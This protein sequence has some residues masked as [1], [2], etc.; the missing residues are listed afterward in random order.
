MFAQFMTIADELGWD[1]ERQ[2]EVLEEFVDG[3]GASGRLED[4]LRMRGVN[5]ARLA[6]TALLRDTVLDFVESL[7]CRG[8]FSH[9]L[10]RKLREAA[11][12]A[13]AD[14]HGPAA[15]APAAPRTD[16]RPPR[17]APSTDG[18]P[19]RRG[20]LAWLRRRQRGSSAEA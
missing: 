8:V 15:E 11:E 16:T 12:A 4:C 6:G 17:S 20:V 19:R 3:F 9:F 5:P 14:V 18:K 7:G 10:Q 13:R 2:I 1:V